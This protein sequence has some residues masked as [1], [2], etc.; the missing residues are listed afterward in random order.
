MCVEENIKLKEANEK[1]R[2]A[3]HNLKSKCEIMQRKLDLL[4]D[5]SQPQS[6]ISNTNNNKRVRFG[7]GDQQNKSQGSQMGQRLV[8]ALLAKSGIAPVSDAETA[9]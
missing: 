5:G 8:Q 2:Q 7:A 4:Y 3:N 9:K 1:L 6:P